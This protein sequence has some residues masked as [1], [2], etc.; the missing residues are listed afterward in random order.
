VSIDITFYPQSAT[1]DDLRT[2]LVSCGFHKAGHF[3]LWAWPE[4]S[5]HFWWFDENDFK[6]ADGVEATIFPPD[7]EEKKRQ[8]CGDWALHV[9]TRSS[10]SSFD[11]EQQNN[12][13][14]TARKTFGGFFI[15]EGRKNRYIKVEPDK[16]SPAGRGIFQTY[17]FIKNQIAAVKYSLPQPLSITPEQDRLLGGILSQSDPVRVLY[18]ALVPFAVAALEHFF[19]QTFRI[20][21]QYDAKAYDR[22]AEE[23]RKVAIADVVAISQG[24]K[25]LEDIVANWYSFQSIAGIHRAFHEWFGVDFW[26]FLRKRNRIG[27]RITRLEERLDQVIKFRHGIIH[28]FEFDVELDRER[29]EEI[30]DSILI[31]I[32]VFID[33]LEEDRGLAIRDS[34]H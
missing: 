7:G 25:T 13:I 18:N 6:S 3:S 2:H 28:R 14:R 21:L 30:L 17:E 8:G 1:K 23:T 9:R 33:H 4:G 29:I 24:T 19:G 27:R 20:L 31:L 22:L 15:N 34:C 26:E 11:R 5:L 12:V 10:A 32:E 16:R